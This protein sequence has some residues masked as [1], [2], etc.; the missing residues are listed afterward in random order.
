MYEI[1]LM[2]LHLPLIASEILAVQSKDT[3]ASDIYGQDNVD[4]Q[5]KTAVFTAALGGYAIALYAGTASL[6][7]IKT[8][9][10]NPKPQHHNEALAT[11][12]AG[13]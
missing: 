9:F 12:D 1:S 2:H 8:V 6:A 11:Q 7:G 13:N 3:S 4:K 5:D 10:D